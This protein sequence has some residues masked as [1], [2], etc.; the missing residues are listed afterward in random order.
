VP[1]FQLT[2]DINGDAAGGFTTLV[3]E[4]YNSANDVQNN[5]WQE[6]QP[7]DEGQNVASSRVLNADCTTSAGGNPAGAPF[8]S[9]ASIAAR[10]PDAVVIEIGV[11]VGSSNPNYVTAVDDIEV[12]VADND[13]D[14]SDP[15]TR[16]FD[17]GPK[18]TGA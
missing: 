8:E 18:G 9:Y 3:Y 10:C 6:W 4:P 7:T 12:Q 13:D 11:N 17:F 5:V 1:S 2:A 15:Q 16:T 14:G